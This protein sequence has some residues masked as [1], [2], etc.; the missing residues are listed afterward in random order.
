M[1]NKEIG[2][3][4]DTADRPGR[5]AFTFLLLGLILLLSYASLRPPAPKPASAPP[6]EFSAERAREIL[7]RLVGDGVPH[8]TGSAHNEVV[9]GRVMNEFTRLGYRPQIQSGFSCDE[10]GTC[11]TVQNVIARLDGAVTGPAV[12]LA[13]HYDSV[14]AGPGASDDG[15]GAASVLE[16]A[17]A[18]KS[19]PTPKNSVIFLI[20]DGEEAGLLGARVF[21]DQNLG[22]KEVRVAV[23]IDN[24]G[25]SGPSL[26]YETGD[27]NSWAMR[28]YVRKVSRPA[29]NSLLYFA[30]KNLPADTDFTVFKQAGYQG[31]NFA[32][33]GDV[34]QYHTP[35]D[36][37]GNANSATLQHHGDNALASVRAFAETQIT[38]PPKSSSAYFDLFER[39][40]IS[41]P[42]P[43]GLQIAMAS[44]FLLF[45]E[46]VWLMYK[47]Y[48]TIAAWLWGCFFWLATIFTTGVLAWILQFA[49]RKL[50]AEPA[51][52]V[53]HPLAIQVAFWSLAVAMICIFSIRF[54]RRSGEL[55][56][57][58]GVWT[59]WAVLGIFLGSR[60]PAASYILQV[61]TAVA[62][63]AA[64][65]FVFRREDSRYPGFVVGSMLPV[66]AVAVVAFGTVLMLY[67]G[68]G[69]PI[70]PVV[71]ILLAFLLTPIAPL[72]GE[73]PS[74]RGLSRLALPGLAIVLTLAAAFMAVVVPAFSAKSP[75][76]VNFEY[77]QDSDTGKSQWVM[78][79]ASGKLPEP[80]R[81]ATNAARQ[82]AGPYPWIPE[83]AYVTNAPH[84]DL[85]PPTFTI[86]ESTEMPGKR[87]YR[88]LLRS[89]RGASRALVYFPPDSGVDAVQVEGHA[90]LPESETIRR[91]LNGWFVYSCETIPAKGIE[92]R[93]TLPPGKAVH[94]DAVDTSF[95]LPL[96]GMFLLK[97]RPF[98]ATPYGD[99]D[100]TV[101]VRHV[102]LLP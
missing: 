80:I 94:V 25:T 42:A 70:L 51:D 33:V 14:P 99:G 88:T 37:F 11:A 49:L 9:R 10:Y 90:V 1:R 17:R 22:A 59:C 62:S 46:I 84:L 18:F 101:V 8:P 21:V 67:P 58:A 4:P 19:L 61:A 85:P 91:E 28:Q 76:H 68:F 23:N 29:T 72:C 30:Y 5:I 6:Q 24:R 41:W 7:N 96:E 87:G 73:L 89:E 63:L 13:A 81:L 64:L 50:G 77:V 15:M 52:W 56:L 26:M 35:L 39:W 97:S 16:I 79:P 44:T 48:L 82:N 38:D 75:E 74:A 98:P 20:D 95:T 100:R 86:L 60:A 12:L 43:A 54:A 69:N 3:S 34:V 92:I 65:A 47:K 2:L 83:T 31:V 53:A 27:A 57:W 71:S 40:T 102:E 66:V 45:L 78:Y 55:G 93:F 36:N 32:A